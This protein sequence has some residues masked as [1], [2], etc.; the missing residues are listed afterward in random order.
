M[1]DIVERMLTAI[2]D[3]HM[4]KDKEVTAIYLGWYEM[5]EYKT[6]DIFTYYN[7]PSVKSKEIKFHSCYVYEVVTD[8][9]LN[10][11]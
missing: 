11:I 5:H 1:P 8:S 7:C 10:V 4:Y 6:S 9:H 3:Y 2:R